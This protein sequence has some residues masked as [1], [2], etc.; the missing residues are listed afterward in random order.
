MKVKNHKSAFT[1]IEISIVIL[2]IGILITGIVGSGHLIKKARIFSA[3]S[4][5][6]SSPINAIKS[7]KIWLESSFDEENFRKNISNIPNN[8][9]ISIVGSGP[10]YSNSINKIPAIKFDNT[11]NEN[12]L[13][14]NN[15]QFLNNTDYTV[16]ITEKRISSNEG[17]NYILSDFNE[18]FLLGYESEISIIQTHGDIPSEDNQANIE[19]LISYS[20]KPRIITFTHSS[21]EGNKIYINGILSNEDNSTTAK[22]HI[23]NLSSENILKIG[24]NYN[25]EIG[26]IAIFDQSLK[27][28]ERQ[29]VENYMAEK[30]N[31]PININETAS[32]ITGI[33]TSKGCSQSC[34]ISVIGSSE[35]SSTLEF[36]E[37]ATVNCNQNGYIGTKSYTCQ[38]SSINLTC[39]CD[40]ENGYTL[41]GSSCIKQCSYNIVGAI[42]PNGTVDDGNGIISCSSNNNFAGTAYPYICENST[43][44]SGNCTCNEGYSFNSETQS[45]QQQQLMNCVG[46]DEEI[47]LVESR[48]KIHIFTTV[49]TQNIECNSAGT[50]SVLVVGGG[51]SGGWRGAGGGAGGYIYEE[52]LSI[53]ATSYSVTVGDG[54]KASLSLSQRNSGTVSSFG[55]LIIAEGGGGGGTGSSNNSYKSGLSGGSGGGGSYWGNGSGGSGTDGQGNSGGNGSSGVRSAGGG[56][57]GGSGELSGQSGVGGNGGAGLLNSITGT[58]SYYAGGGGAGSHNS[59]GGVGGSGVGGNGSSKSPLQTEATAGAPNTGSGGGG[60]NNSLY[61]NGAPGG[62]GIVI[63][64][65]NTNL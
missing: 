53:D 10:S 28:I 64:R 29:D 25:G 9:T 55:S 32:C 15:P 57:A 16:I 4:L 43:T 21:Q 3:H 36:E 47:N 58:P 44:I 5:T 65:Y 27:S 59:I 38:G 18:S 56:G 7:N 26:E 17:G 6:K 12:H 51:G 63:V 34:N 1:L 49:G 33:T 24:K 11:S 41:I 42:I 20:N 52:S 61:E 23:N 50:I 54:G 39:D 40:T 13:Q 48:E 45:C 30:W 22:T 14:I 60:G 46:G 8:L 37:S 35:E 2:V 62:S 31:S 19:P